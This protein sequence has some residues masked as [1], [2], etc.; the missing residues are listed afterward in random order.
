VYGTKD[1]DKRAGIFTFN[2]GSLNP[3]DVAMMLDASAGIQVRSGHHCALPLAK[4]LLKAPGGS[5][6][7][8]V[9]IYNNNVEI[10]SLVETLCEIAK[11]VA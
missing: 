5:V 2:I 10:D 3:H 9:Y 7:A 11:T 1:P 4:E 6:R 8:S